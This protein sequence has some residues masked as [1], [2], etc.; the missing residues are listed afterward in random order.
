M[1][2]IFNNPS[3]DYIIPDLAPCAGDGSDTNTFEFLPNEQVGIISG[4]S[5]ISSMNLG[6]ISQSVEGWVQQTKILQAGEVT[7]IPGLT[8]GI[9]SEIQYFPWDGSVAYTGV[10]HELYMSLDISL[11]YYSNF[12]Y[13]DTALHVTADPSNGITIENALN[14][15]LGN[16][17]V[18]MTAD[19]SSYGLI[20]TGSQDGYWF[21]VS[22]IDVSLWE[23]DSLVYSA[24]LIEDASSKVPAYKYP[25]GAMLGY[26]LKITY[27]SITEDSDNYVLINHVPDYFT[28][29]EASTGN[30]DCYIKYV[31]AVDVGLSGISCDPDKI[32]AGDYLYYVQ[33]NEEWEKVGPVRVWL[34]AE[35]PADSNI[36]NLIT[37]FYVFNPHTFAV[38]IDYMT[39]L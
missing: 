11:S 14:I 38:K 15:A 2:D 33:T 36:E 32:S 8:K 29:Y 4:N 26:V 13:Y 24:S 7:Y 9:E 34:T 21:N 27:P 18:L 20:F 28:Y 6:D 19:Y 10:T 30:P 31:K 5:V 23:P 25:N 39:I 37:G 22:A 17:G 1:I 12:K 16:L 35:D 3:N